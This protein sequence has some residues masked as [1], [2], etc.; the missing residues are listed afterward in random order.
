[1]GRGEAMWPERPTHTEEGGSWGETDRQ[2]L[3]PNFP[4]FKYCF[5]EA[6]LHFLETYLLYFVLPFS[7]LCLFL[8]AKSFH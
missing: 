3:D 7:V 4:D 2:N 8:E 5:H 1:M 6:R